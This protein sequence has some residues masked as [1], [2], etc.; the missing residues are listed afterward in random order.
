VPAREEGMP[1]RALALL[2]STAAFLLPD[3]ANAQMYCRESVADKD[4]NI[5]VSV[6]VTDERRDLIVHVKNLDRRRKEITFSECA[7]DLTTIGGTK[8]RSG[9]VLLS[10]YE[11]RPN[12]R[13]IIAPQVPSHVVRSFRTLDTRL[14]QCMYVVKIVEQQAAN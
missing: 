3:S 11:S 13:H 1:G 2:A 8:H 14:I 6:C 9:R 4:Y 5:E 10:V 12:N 7:V